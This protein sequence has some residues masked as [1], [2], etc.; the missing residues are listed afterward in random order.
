PR[1]HP[2]LDLFLAGNGSVDVSKLLEP[3]QPSDTV[4]LGESR[5]QALVVFR[6]AP[7]KVIRHAGVKHARATCQGINPVGADHLPGSSVVS[8]TLS[9]FF[10]LYPPFSRKQA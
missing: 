5:N 9:S 6:N 1:P 2:S 8:W 10:F 7:R 3:D 4:L